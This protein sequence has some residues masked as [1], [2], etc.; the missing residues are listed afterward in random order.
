MPN[1]F[2]GLITD[3]QGHQPERA[4]RDFRLLRP[5]PHFNGANVARRSLRVGTS[6]Y[7]ALQVK[8]DKRFCAV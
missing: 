2:Y 3:P 6:S 4:D 5:M 8:W 1:P 7:H